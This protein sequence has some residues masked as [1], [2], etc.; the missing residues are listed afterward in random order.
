[1]IYGFIIAAG[2]QTRFDDDKPKALVDI[3][4]KS[5]LDINIHNL[6]IVCDSVT[7]VCS[8]E[9]E[10]Y[11]ENYS[12]IVIDSGLGCGDAVFQAL[13]KFKFED[14]D[15]CFIQWGDCFINN[16]RFYKFIK[17][18]YNNKK[19]DIIV[20]CNYEYEPYVKLEEIN[21]KLKVKFS[22]FGEIEKGETGFHDMSV[23]YGNI[24]TIKYYCF[25]FFTH[26]CKD[27]TYE[28][29]HGNEFNF[30][31]LFNDTEIKGKILPINSNKYKCYAFNTKEEYEEILEEVKDWKDF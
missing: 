20:P 24:N 3:K 18:K 5:C 10:K 22:K 12:R 19:S 11:F 17:R 16:S 13:D 8:K 1:M 4:G 25:D 28:H 15:T 21:N 29:Y 31:D 2:N 7:I 30:L 14:N 23:F 26:Y 27:Y 9:N 6:G